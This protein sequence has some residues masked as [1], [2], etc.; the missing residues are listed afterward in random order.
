M[1]LT[2]AVP[3]KGRLEELTREFF[4]KAGVAITRPGGARS[5]AGALDGYPDVTVRFYPRAKSPES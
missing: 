1:S 5:Y 4:A 2:L 3:S